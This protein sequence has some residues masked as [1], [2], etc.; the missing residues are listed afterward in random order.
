MNRL[1]AIDFEHAFQAWK[2]RRRHG[3][4]RD[5]ILVD[6]GHNCIRALYAR[7]GKAGEVAVL[8]YASSR[9]TGYSDGAIVD[10]K[11]FAATMERIVA[12]RLRH[13]G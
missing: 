5:F 9:N 13:R 10:Q 12:V 11:Q 1:A 2:R 6:L 3:N 4:G 8:D 7:I